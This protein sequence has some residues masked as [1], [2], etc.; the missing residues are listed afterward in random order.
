M[1]IRSRLT[2][3]QLLAGAGSLGI[4]AGLY[5]PAAAQK[6]T[7]DEGFDPLWRDAEAA[8]DAFF[9][10]DAEFTYEGMYLELPQ[11]ADVGNSV[12]MTIRFDS[13]MTEE[14]YP[15][16]VHVYSQW[17]PTPQIVSAWFT[18]QAGRGEFTTRIRLDT[19]QVVTAIAQMSDGRLI[20]A[21]SPVSVSFGACGEDGSGNNDTV[22]SFKPITR[23]SVPLTARR[24]DIIPIRAVI[25]H[26]Q[27]TGLRRDVGLEFIRQR[28]VSRFGC[29]F[30]GVE[31]FKARLYSAVSANPYLSFYARAEKSGTYHFS[32]YDTNN[33]TFTNQATILVT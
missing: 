1:H 32:W 16:L 23:V 15:I 25:S 7:D 18:P 28:I 31:F 14:D 6:V 24:G 19:T 27:E 11:H 26:P 22:Q 5:G 13:A 21:D 33:L 12:P 2:R 29:T 8:I 3:R 30:D 10:R 4:A 9:G 17:N 20:R